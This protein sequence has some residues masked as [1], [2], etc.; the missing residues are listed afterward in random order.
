MV[1]RPSARHPGMSVFY[2]S[3]PV[4]IAFALGLPVLLQGGTAMVLAGHLY[5][6]LYTFSVL[7]LLLL[8][9]LASLRE[10]FRMRSVIF[11]AAIGWWWIGLGLAMVTIVLVGAISLPMPSM[12]GMAAIEEH[13]IDYWT[14]GST[15]E[16]QQPA[17]RAAVALQESQVVYKVRVG[18]LVFL[19]IV[20]LFAALRGLGGVG[21]WIGRNRHRFPRPVVRIFTWLDALLERL[22]TFPQLPRIGLRRRISA[23]VALSSKFH[24]PMRGEGVGTVSEVQA[25]VAKS[26][27]ALCALAADLGHPKPH[28]MTPYEFLNPLPRE[29]SGLTAEARELTG[30]YVL[31][32]Y[33]DHRPDERVLDRLRRFWV[34]YEQ[35][36]HGLIR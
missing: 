8:S 12:P 2:F 11:P 10:Y 15:F 36:R 17:T 29:M 21:A 31:S 5:V 16:L 6:C 32:E 18:V 33:S 28:D 27:D 14:R 1:E 9:S 26:Y 13:E 24:N 34:A 25:A 30:L 3:V 22:L 35:V 20:V 7:M 19:G 23:E 4:M